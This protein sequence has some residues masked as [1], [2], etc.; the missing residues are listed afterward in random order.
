MVR[1][2]GLLETS[3]AAH[4]LDGFFAARLRKKGTPP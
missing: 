2:P 4:D 1:D 3:P